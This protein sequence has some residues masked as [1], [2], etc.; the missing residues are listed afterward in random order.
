[1]KDIGKKSLQREAGIQPRTWRDE[2]KKAIE[3]LPFVY[4][5]HAFQ[6]QLA[7]PHEVQP[8]IILIQAVKSL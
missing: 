8:R 6:I 2:G 1:M 3:S 5:L 4:K 7:A